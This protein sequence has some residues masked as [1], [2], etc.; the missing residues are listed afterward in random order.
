MSDIDLSKYEVIACTT[1]NG[2]PPQGFL[3]DAICK[4]CGNAGFTLKEI[5]KISMVSYSITIVP[6]PQS[7]KT[8]IISD[9]EQEGLI[10]K[11]NNFIPPKLE[12]LVPPDEDFISAE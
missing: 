7:G 5:G 4:S 10:G 1:C 11:L 8:E 3:M 9:L 12:D 2:I 6:A